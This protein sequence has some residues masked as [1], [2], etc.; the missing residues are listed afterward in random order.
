MPQL[1][2]HSEE[3]ITRR[4]KALR[5]E[6]VSPG[7]IES[8]YGLEEFGAETEL[9]K[10][11]SAW[12]ERHYREDQE[13]FD[14][15]KIHRWRLETFFQNKEL[16]PVKWAAV[17]LGMTEESLEEVVQA[18]EREKLL[19]PDTIRDGLIRENA[20]EGLQK[21][22][23]S[24]RRRIFADIQDFCS[25]LHEAIRDEL[26]VEV[27]PLYCVTSETLREEDPLY[28]QGFDSLTDEPTSSHYEH[29]LE[30]GKPN[31]LRPD[32]C[33]TVTLVQF[34]DLLEE[35]LFTPAKGEIVNPVKNSQAFGHG[36]G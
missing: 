4:L 19:E 13:P 11:F 24:L 2:E 30:T 8:L 28:A 22:F 27:T 9:G 35:Y 26:N 17:R 3:S 12:A 16:L 21:N 33:S 7:L 1:P 32:T 34:E 14:G 31:F 5:Q 6:F 25:S 23:E 20:V 29:W 15:E 10:R 18:L 36:D